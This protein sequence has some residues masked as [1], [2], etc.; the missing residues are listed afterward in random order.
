MKLSKQ[1]KLIGHLAQEM[2]PSEVGELLAASPSFSQK[3]KEECQTPIKFLITLKRKKCTEA[4]FIAE[5]ER[6][7]KVCNFAHFVKKTEDHK[8]GSL[9]GSYLK[10]QPNEAPN[11]AILQ[12][13]SEYFRGVLMNMSHA[14]PQKQ[15]EIMVALAPI[16]EGSK[17]DIKHG[18]QLFEQLER[19]GCIGEND[20]ELLQEMFELLQLAKVKALLLQY[21]TARSPSESPPSLGYA[22][23]TTQTSDH[24]PSMISGGG[25]QPSSMPRSVISAI[26]TTVHSLLQSNP[27]SSHSSERRKRNREYVL[28]ETAST[29]PPKVSHLA[30][31]PSS[32]S[33]ESRPPLVFIENIHISCVFPAANHENRID[34]EVPLT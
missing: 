34:Q 29:P 19:H 8:R 3:E 16:P 2:K 10:F 7:F 9:D 27:T 21:T 12:H 33:M 18:Y 6:L 17:E 13:G 11:H 28:D 25:H 14:I 30:V 4:E 1:Q 23:Q 15:L 5:L 26:T 31:T 20:M 24:H 22:A 32:E